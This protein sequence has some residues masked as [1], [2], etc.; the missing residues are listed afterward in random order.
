VIC[1]MHIVALRWGWAGEKVVPSGLAQSYARSQVLDHFSLSG[2]G[3]AFTNGQ[4]ADQRL[5]I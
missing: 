2:W 1:I 4:V 3:E 5:A